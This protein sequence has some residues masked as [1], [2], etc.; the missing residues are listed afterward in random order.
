MIFEIG[1]MDRYISEKEYSINS[2]RLDVV[3]RRVERSVPTYAFEVQIG[4]NPYQVLAK[5]HHAY[6]IWNSNIY[7]ITEN[8]QR[9]KIDEILGGSF[10]EIKNVVNVANLG[11]V[12]DLY[13]AQLKDVALRHQIGLP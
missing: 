11:Q 2:D 12:K 10:Y 7:L 9:D 4:G 3:W 13:S 5:L 6:N 1:K 8:E